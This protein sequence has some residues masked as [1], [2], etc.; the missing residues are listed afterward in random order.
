MSHLY[1]TILSSAFVIEVFCT[2]TDSLGSGSISIK[3]VSLGH[4]AIDYSAAA[5]HF[6]SWGPLPSSAQKNWPERK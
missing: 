4:F 2:E 5:S 3:S 6:A 1:D